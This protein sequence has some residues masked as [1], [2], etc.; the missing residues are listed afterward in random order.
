[1][2]EPTAESGNRAASPAS[3]QLRIVR[4][5]LGWIRPGVGQT[6]AVYG[7][8]ILWLG[9]HGILVFVA[10]YALFD[11]FTVISWGMDDVLLLLILVILSAGTWVLCLHAVVDLQRRLRRRTRRTRILILPGLALIAVLLFTSLYLK[12]WSL[13]EPEIGFLLLLTLELVL[14]AGGVLRLMQWAWRGFLFDPGGPGTSR[15]RRALIYLLVIPLMVLG[16][17][18]FRYR[19]LRTA[20]DFFYPG[21]S[22]GNPYWVQALDKKVKNSRDRDTVLVAALAHHLRGERA[23]AEKLYASLPDDP[24]AEKNR[25]ALARGKPPVVY[26]GIRSFQHALAPPLPARSEVPGWLYWMHGILNGELFGF[27]GDDSEPEILRRVLAPMT[28]VLFLMLISGFSLGYRRSRT[29]LHAEVAPERE[30]KEPDRMGL[31]DVFMSIL[32]PGYTA[33]PRVSPVWTAAIAFMYFCPFLVWFILGNEWYWRFALGTYFQ[34]RRILGIHGLGSA[35]KFY[36]HVPWL[37][38]LV[39]MTPVMAATAVGLQAGMSWRAI[40][41][42]RR[43]AGEGRVSRTQAL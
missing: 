21:P 12:R 32:L 39:M 38:P 10:F 8:W 7:C 18:V 37:G 40:R 19:D 23:E 13:P 42:W 3:P 6:R 27:P 14:L 22:L 4:R 24:V 29:G 5:I 35:L 26:P 43:V 36:T 41:A 16:V 30:A 20:D 28:P 33:S 34:L 25:E 11:P 15:I 9:V 1:M 17:F 2:L 31:S